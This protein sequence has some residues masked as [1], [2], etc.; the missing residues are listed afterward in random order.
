MDPLTVRLIVVS[1]SLGSYAAA[2]L[3]ARRR[4]ADLAKAE[5]K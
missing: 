5:G 2:A 3:V 4:K 1:C